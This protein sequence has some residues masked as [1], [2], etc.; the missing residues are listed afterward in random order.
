VNKTISDCL[1]LAIITLGIS[2]LIWLPYLL[3]INFYGLDFSGG[4]STIYR[5]FD[6]TE[7][8]TV[9]KTLYNPVALAS[10]P[11]TFSPLY[12]ASH[13]PLYPLFITFFA[14]ILGYLKSMIFVTLLFT[15]LSVWAFYFLV[16]DFKFSNQS[17]FLSL[18]FLILP[19][20]W[21]I[22]HSV[23]SPEPVFIFFTIA[24]LYSFLKFE[25][26]KIKSMLWASAI[27]AA[28]AQLTRSPG[29]LLFIALAIYIHYQMYLEKIHTNF[30]LAFKHHLRYWPF[31]LVPVSLLGIFFLYSKNLGDFWA[32]FHSGDNIHLTFPPFQIFN[33]DQFWVGDIWLEDVIYIFLAGFMGGL[34]LLKNKVTKPLGFFVLTYLA[35]AILVVHR[36][37]S[38]Y[39]LPVMPFVIIA[40]EKALTSKE[41]K[42][43]LVILALGI[44]LYSQNFIIHNIAPIP[45][46]AA[47]N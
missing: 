37:I 20:R 39:T 14:T 46:L 28:L 41:F 47:F 34:L 4:F 22:V 43:V 24:S 19:A 25:E 6:G 38:R 36:D 26:T 21:I 32:Y 9:A 7:Y 16:R 13:F 11:Q 10:L 2:F 42:I 23:G 31:L 5:N 45:N 8:I 33:K 1:K 29:I 40:F 27:F 30:S 35:A 3:K 12:Y 44:Y 17:F 18:V 15:V